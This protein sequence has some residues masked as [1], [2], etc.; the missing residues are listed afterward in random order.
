MV[1]FPIL[2]SYSCRRGKKGRPGGRWCRLLVIK[3]KLC[4]NGEWGGF[5]TIFGG[6]VRSCLR[7]INLCSGLVAYTPQLIFQRCSPLVVADSGLN[8]FDMR[9]G[10]RAG[11][12]GVEHPLDLLSP[13]SSTSSS[14][15]PTSPSLILWLSISTSSYIHP[16]YSRLSTIKES[17]SK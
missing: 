4:V 9:S 7:C 13:G 17:L 14:T 16:Y 3:G 5:G 6:S 11:W 2:P 10:H 8:R 12:Y 1:C 15:S